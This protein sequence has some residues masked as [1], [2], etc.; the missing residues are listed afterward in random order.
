MSG[1]DLAFR[2]HRTGLSAVDDTD[3]DKI[4]DSTPSPEFVSPF[5]A[6]RAREIHIVAKFTNVAQSVTLVPV[7]SKK[8]IQ[9]VETLIGPG[10][11][12]VLTAG[13]FT[14]GAAPFFAPEAIKINP[15]ADFGRFLV[16]V[17]PVAGTVDLDVGTLA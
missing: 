6:G 7:W 10:P 2:S 1:L 8:D 9:G 3:L 4:L 12:F 11:A 15:G 13:V 17:A 14:K 5:K 16:T